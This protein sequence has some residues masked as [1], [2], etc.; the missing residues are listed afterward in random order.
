MR[1]HV[2][3]GIISNVTESLFTYE[4]SGSSFSDLHDRNFT[5][6]FEAVFSSPELQARAEMVCE[7]DVFCM[8]DT[9]ATGDIA[10]GLAT[11]GGGKELE[12]IANNSQPGVGAMIPSF[13]VCSATSIIYTLIP[14][15]PPCPVLCNPPCANGAC[16]DNNTCSCSEGYR[17]DRCT[18]AG[19]TSCV[20]YIVIRQFYKGQHVEQG[21]THIPHICIMQCSRPVR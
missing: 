20:H 2:N 9:A 8:Y 10:I 5:P 13:A 3:A 4:N 6:A 18:D 14:L 12:M 1:A 16:V 19:S 17:G 15:L 21:N 11:L 7:G